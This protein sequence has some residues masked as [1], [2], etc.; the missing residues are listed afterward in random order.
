VRD[1]AKIT[2][3]AWIHQLARR[4]KKPCAGEI[5]PQI[6]GPPSHSIARS[7]PPTSLIHNEAIQ[8]ATSGVAPKAVGQR[9]CTQI[10]GPNG[11]MEAGRWERFGA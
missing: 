1:D 5:S 8:C 11:E 4:R 2:D 9:C 3:E 7:R 10:G 6:G